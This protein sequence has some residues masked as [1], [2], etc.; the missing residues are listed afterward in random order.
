MKPIEVQ[1]PVV[2][3]LGIRIAPPA[4]VF[5][6][7]Y[8]LDVGFSFDRHVLSANAAGNFSD[9][10]NRHRI[11]ALQIAAEFP[12]NDRRITNHA[13]TAEIALAR[14]M[15]VAASPNRSA[16]AGSDFVIAE[17]DV[18]AAA[19]T[20]G[21]GRLIANFVFAFAFE[22]GNEAIALPA[23]DALQLSME[24]QFLRRSGLIFQFQARLVRGR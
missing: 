18:R 3:L 6:N 16:K 12:F 9:Q 13:R 11:L 24:R 20:I 14:E 8:V 2:D 7:D 17:I 1:F 5:P 19:G 22:T 4:G 23:P 10:V 15:D 21:R